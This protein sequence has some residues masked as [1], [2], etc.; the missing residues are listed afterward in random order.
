MVYSAGWIRVMGVWRV[1]S[2]QWQENRVGALSAQCRVAAAARVDVLRLGPVPHHPCLAHVKLRCGP[3]VPEIPSAP[4][5]RNTDATPLP[6]KSYTCTCTEAAI[7]TA[8]G[9]LI[10]P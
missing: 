1:Y 6:S 8:Y 3:L 4:N 7:L 2:R 5:S 9:R 10:G